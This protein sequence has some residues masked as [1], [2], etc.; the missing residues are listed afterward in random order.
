[1]LI[2]VHDELLLEAPIDE[3]EKAMALLKEEMERAAQLS[4]KLLVE[5]HSGNNWVEAK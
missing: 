5:V 3:K 2:Q 1:M 4:V